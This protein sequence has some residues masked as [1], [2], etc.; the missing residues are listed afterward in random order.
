MLKNS[1]PESSHTKPPEEPD[2]SGEKLESVERLSRL[3]S[4]IQELEEAA[5]FL[6]RTRKKFPPATQRYH[7]ALARKYVSQLKVLYY[8]KKQILGY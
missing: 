6:S 2:A 3:E 1:E 7:Q 4:Q 5:L 8:Q